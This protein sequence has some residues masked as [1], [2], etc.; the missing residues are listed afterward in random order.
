MEKEPAMKKKLFHFF[1][2][3]LFNSLTLLAMD[4]SLLM[5]THTDPS[6]M[7]FEQRRTPMPHATA[8]LQGG[9][10]AF[11][12]VA[13]LRRREATSDETASSFASFFS[14][15]AARA[16]REGGAELPAIRETAAT[17]ATSGGTFANPNYETHGRADWQYGCYA[18][19]IETPVPLTLVIAGTEKQVA[20]SNGVMQA[21]NVKGSAADWSW[22]IA[23]ESA[24]TVRFGFGVNPLVDFFNVNGAMSIFSRLGMGI[25]AGGI[26]ADLTN[27]WVMVVSRARIEGATV[28]YAID[29][30][31]WDGETWHEEEATKT[32]PAAAFAR[33]ARTEF[34]TFGVAGGAT[35]GT[36]H[37]WD[38]YG[39]KVFGLWLSDDEV[40]TVRDLDM[41]EMRRRGMTQWASEEIVQ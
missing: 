8:W 22:S 40:R 34:L 1:T 17:A 18:V 36:P 9:E 35:D 12:H 19:N 41:F 15:E 23:G 7:R 33:N 27:E 31:R 26:V 11:T 24:A 6:R 30:L 38:E 4:P 39:A 29:A 28:C 16:T 13:W 10:T 14:V 5:R 2:L 21:F 3:S 32:A 20:A 37:L 25:E